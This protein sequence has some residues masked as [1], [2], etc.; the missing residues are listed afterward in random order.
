[1]AYSPEYINSMKNSNQLHFGHLK[2]NA[3]EPVTPPVWLANF[4]DDRGG[5]GPVYLVGRYGRQPV[6]RTSNVVASYLKNQQH[7]NKFTI[8]WPPIFCDLWISQCDIVQTDFLIRD[9]VPAFV[10]YMD[11]VARENVPNAADSNKNVDHHPSSHSQ[12]Q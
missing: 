7:E 9:T 5:A 10:P 8:F 11:N 2:S 6:Y 1:M 12:P 3:A 4:S